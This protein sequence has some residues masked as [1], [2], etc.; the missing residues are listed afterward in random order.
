M[1]AT[2]TSLNVA[3]LEWMA[4]HGIQS[5]QDCPVLKVSLAGYADDG[6][7]LFHIRPAYDVEI[8]AAGMDGGKN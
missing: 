6:T 8:A 1:S 5:G 7:P 2:Q 4:R 3:L